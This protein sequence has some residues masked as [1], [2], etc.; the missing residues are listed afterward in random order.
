MTSLVIVAFLGKVMHGWQIRDF[1]VISGWRLAPD[2]PVLVAA[3][4]SP[5]NEAIASI[6]SMASGIVIGHQRGLF[7]CISQHSKSST[8]KSKALFFLP[9][10]GLF[11][12]ALLR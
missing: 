9:K 2:C 8:L 11:C 3:N 7:L 1:T 10:F 6:A 12:S 5:N 4:S